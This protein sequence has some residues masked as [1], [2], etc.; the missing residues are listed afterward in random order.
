MRGE[1]FGDRR[2]GAGGDGGVSTSERMSNENQHKRKRA[3]ADQT[4]AC[5]IGPLSYKS[6]PMEVESEEP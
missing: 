4:R 3:H 5:L 2:C 6:A 1:I